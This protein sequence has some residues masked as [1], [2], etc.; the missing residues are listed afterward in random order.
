[1][2]KI[3]ST[4]TEEKAKKK[5][6]IKACALTLYQK[7]GELC[8]VDKIV[9]KSGVAKGTFYLY[10]KTKEEVFL[11][12]LSDMYAVYLED[13]FKGIDLNKVTLESLADSLVKPL[14]GNS[15]FLRLASIG[16]GILEKNVSEEKIIEF[17]L[18]LMQAMQKMGE[19]F[20]QLSPRL[21]PEKVSEMIVVSFS[22]IIGI[23]QQSDIS[24]ELKKL[25]EKPEI[26]DLFIDF[27]KITSRSLVALW[28]GWI[29]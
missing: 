25:S 17:K 28:K 13:V 15:D 3:R 10:F 5:E 2:A 19:V 16:P 7:S 8:S 1:L 20:L 24:G 14:V 26:K 11:D 27:E 23:F 29:I 22:L 18:M 21:K 4:S 9:K 6:H 12:I